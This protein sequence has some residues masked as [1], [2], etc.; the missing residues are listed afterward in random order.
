MFSLIDGPSIPVPTSPKTHRI[1]DPPAD[2]VPGDRI[3]LVGIPPISGQS[4]QC[5]LLRVT[6]DGWSSARE[7][8]VS[9]PMSLGA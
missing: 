2:Y 4:L 3:A 8:S 7:G 1:R 9:G 6:L 5:R